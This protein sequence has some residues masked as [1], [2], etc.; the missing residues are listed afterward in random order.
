M[1]SY[2]GIIMHFVFLFNTFLSLCT[3]TKITANT[4]SQYPRLYVMYTGSEWPLIS[5]SHRLSQAKPGE[6]KKKDKIIKFQQNDPPFL[7]LQLKH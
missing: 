7:P 1:T 5:W 6:K 2:K 3:F 4:L